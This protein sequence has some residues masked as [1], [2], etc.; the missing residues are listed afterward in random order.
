MTFEKTHKV[1]ISH[2]SPNGLGVA[3][4]SEKSSKKNIELPYTLPGEQ[5]LIHE[6]QGK[7]KTHYSLAQIL[8][9][10]KARTPS[11][12]P[13]FERCG[14]CLLLHASPETQAS[15]KEYKLFRAFNYGDFKLNSR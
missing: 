8:K 11:P 6:M 3:E 2:L 12:C 13:Y 9:P 7:K 15:F 14:G 5:L 4:I 10:S 1:S